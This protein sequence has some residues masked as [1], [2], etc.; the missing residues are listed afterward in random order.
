MAHRECQYCLDTSGLSNPLE[1]MPEDIHSILW[2]K[3]KSL[4]KSGQFAVTREIYNELVRL[5]GSVG[6]CIK[7]SKSVLVFEV[8]DGAWDWVSYIGHV[9]RMRE[10]H[11]GF[12]SEYNGNRK[13][14]IGL[15]DL[16]IVALALTIRL[17]VLSM[18]ADSFQASATKVRIPRLCA[19]EGVMHTTFNQLLRAEGITN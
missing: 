6:D 11:K 15:N 4:I 19:L 14:T 7:A 2:S 18:E 9:N 8:G 10:A 5:S 1:T 17:P 13:G 12:I 16:S 3:I